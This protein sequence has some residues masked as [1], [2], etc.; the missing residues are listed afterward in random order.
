MP[1][2]IG[3]IRNGIILLVY[4]VI[5]I[6]LYLFLSEPYDNIMTSMENING[7]TDSQVE[8]GATV[9]RI[10]FDMMFAILGAVPIIWFIV[11]SMSREPD[12]G[13]RP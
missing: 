6:A 10:V 2:S 9:N 13:Y 11:W 4:L 7:S 3:I 8:A 12:W 5:I 1:V